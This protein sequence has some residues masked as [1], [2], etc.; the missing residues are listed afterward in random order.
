MDDADTERK[1][2]V[3]QATTQGVA[4]IL[5]ADCAKPIGRFSKVSDDGL[6]RKGQCAENT[7]A[8]KTEFDFWVLAGESDG[9]KFSGSNS[10][11]TAGKLQCHGRR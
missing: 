5:L 10:F 8:R 9:G 4:G 2:V 1:R 7:A 3:N 6:D 11:E